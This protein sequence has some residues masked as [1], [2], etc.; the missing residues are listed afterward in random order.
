[1]K[2]VVKERDINKRGLLHCEI[3]EGMFPHEC[4]AVA[5]RSDG[6]Y[7]S[8]F[9]MREFANFEKQTLSVEVCFERDGEYCVWVPENNCAGLGWLPGSKMMVPKSNVSFEKRKDGTPKKKKK[10]R[11]A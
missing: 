3:A 9:F 4:S 11:P 2:K 6:T 1:M 10:Q 7:F 5:K 8:G